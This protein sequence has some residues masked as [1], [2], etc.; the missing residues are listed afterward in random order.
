MQ[1]I[2]KRWASLSST[3]TR[4]YYFCNIS[5][6]EYSK[7]SWMYIKNVIPQNRYTLLKLM[8]LLLYVHIYKPKRFLL[9]Q[10]RVLIYLV[11]GYVKFLVVFFNFVASITINSKD[12]KKSVFVM[13]NR[14]TCSWPILL[15]PSTGSWL[16]YFI[17][18][19]RYSTVIHFSIHNFIFLP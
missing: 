1:W 12:V 11:V 16:S 18:H 9:K 19:P 6:N 15:L 10:T 8:C 13:K 4:R 2:K 5:D 17:L 14:T 3:S 7:T